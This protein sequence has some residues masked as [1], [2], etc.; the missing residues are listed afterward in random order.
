[1]ISSENSPIACTV[2]GEKRR[3]FPVDAGRGFICGVHVDQTK[4][5]IK[6]LILIGM[7]GG[8]EKHK[9]KDSHPI[10]YVTKIF[11]E[12]DFQRH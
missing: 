8:V 9:A 2:R 4:P 5:D 6:H 7:M 12:I 11:Y 10:R 1:M 3:A